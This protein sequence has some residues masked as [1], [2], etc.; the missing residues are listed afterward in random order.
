VSGVSGVGGWGRGLLRLGQTLEVRVD[1]GLIY[2]IL[3]QTVLARPT[4]LDR[5]KNPIF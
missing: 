2:I 4:R 3:L 1:F 5:T